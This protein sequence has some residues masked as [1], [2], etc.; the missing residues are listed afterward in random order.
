MF[1]RTSLA[2]VLG[3]A[4]AS[5]IAMDHTRAPRTVMEA[6]VTVFAAPRWARGARVTG[7]EPVALQFFLKH[8]PYQM[9]KFH[10]DLT[11]RSDPAS[12]NYAQWLDVDGVKARLVPSTE[13][14]DVVMAFARGMGADPKVDK[15]A[16]VVSVV[17]PAKA[18]EEHLE[19]TLHHHGHKERNAQLIRA[20]EPYS[21]P[22][23]VA[24]Y[25]SVVG[26]LVRFPRMKPAA[27]VQEIFASETVN[28][29]SA[30][31]KCGASYSGFTNP[32]VLAERYGFEFP[33]TTHAHGN[34]LGLAEFQRQYYDDADLNAF[35]TACGLKTN[36][37]VHKVEGG[38][39]P[40]TCS[41][42]FQGCVESLLDIE[43]AGAVAGSIPLVVYYSNDYSLLAWANDLLS[44]DGVPPVHSVSYGN[45][46]AQQTGR[47]FVDSVNAAFAKLS[48]TGVTILFAAG[49]QGV[50]GREGPGTKYHPD[51][52]A[53]SP[54]VTAVG[55]TDLITKS[56][57]GEETTWADG[58]SGFSN[59]FGRPA[60]QDSYVQ[61]YL[62]EAKGSLPKF[63][64]VY[65]KS[66]R[67]YPDVSALAGL[68]N[69]Y[70]VA[71][72]GGKRFASVGGTS[73]AA[74][75]VAG[76]IAQ[77]ND[78]RLSAGKPTLGWLNPAL[79][80]C[81]EGVYNDVTTGKTS[82]GIVGGFPAAKGWDAATGFGT[83]QYKPLA[84]CLVKN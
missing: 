25:V 33:K 37:T 22:E 47:A 57:I 18:V 56:T 26:D 13:A 78:R 58:G 14:L 27:L 49:D 9:A 10:A 35:T 77:I 70:L 50:W 61:K 17:V 19:T 28:A 44:K 79:Y 1:F 29:D 36:V 74:P 73:A 34:A 46:E 23:D 7:D 66:G 65:N 83:I 24:K 4:A 2:V 84:K 32:H 64:N 3:A 12:P 59:D 81:G 63:P 82:G 76:I 43:Y 67:A 11:D 20:T 52:P 40:A 42:G 62:K 68:V 69:P 71:L 21:L 8:C 45:D 75:V 51:F 38:N 60:W 55:G 16:S 15:F 5:A 53:G 48:A 41:S 72:E 30:W 31:T 54:Y 6:D 39:V 80:A